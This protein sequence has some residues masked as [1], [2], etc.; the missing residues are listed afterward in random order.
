VVIDGGGVDT[1]VVSVAYDIS[2][3]TAIENITGTGAASLML[4]G[5]AFDNV[6]TGNDA[7]NVIYGHGGNDVLFG[8]AGNDRIHGGDGRD[9]MWGGS[10]R[11]IFVFDRKPN[12][13]HKDRIEDFNVREDSI[14]VENKY[15]K[16]GKKG[17]ITKPAK[18]KSK[19]FYSGKKAHDRDDRFIYDKKKGKL[20]YDADGTGSKKAIEI[21]QLDTKLKIK[22]ADFFVI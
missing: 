19:M 6:L 3:L 20:W 7:A 10:G 13:K 8:G 4:T 22:S 18:L 11:D 21:A 15:F 1:V 5:N 17:S 2:S 12:K 9:V 14:F 16:V